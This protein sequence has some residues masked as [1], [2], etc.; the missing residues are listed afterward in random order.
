MT[1][2]DTPE[3]GMHGIEAVT[4][5]LDRKRAPYELIEH[6]DTFAAVDE[7]DATGSALG[8]MAKTVL[9]H[10]HGG[11]CA[12]V[13]P[14]SERVDLHKARAAAGHWALAAGER[15]A[16]RA[17]VPRVRRRRGAPFSALLQTPGILDTRLLAYRQVL[18][19]G[20]DHRYTL[21][22]SPREIERLGQPLV[23]DVCQAHRALT[24]KEKFL[25]DQPEGDPMPATKKPARR[26][27]TTAARA[28]AEDSERTLDHVMQSLEAAQKDLASIGGS[29]GTGV[30]DLR[31]DVNRLLR[32]ARRDVVKMRRA[33]QRDLV[34]L[35]KDLSAAATAKPAAARLGAATTTRTAGRRTEASAH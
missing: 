18:C 28:R 13:I 14:A 29:L 15:G 9:L 7:A 12:A 6:T 20:G 25:T 17:R 21:K 33:V 26:R 1:V 27:A 23:A 31:R 2:D 5:F 4:Y 35:Q 11:F 24:E 34:R 8:R 32:D 19:S 3:Q 30:R 16:D 22:I 10:D